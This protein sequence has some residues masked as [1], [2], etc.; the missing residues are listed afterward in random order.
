VETQSHLVLRN[1]DLSS[2]FA[3]FTSRAP[4]SNPPVPTPSP[5]LIRPSCAPTHGSQK[6]LAT[7]SWSSLR[8]TTS[9]SCF[10]FHVR[11]TQRCSKA[12]SV[13]IS[14]LSTDLQKSARAQQSLQYCSY[15]SHGYECAPACIFC[16]S[17]AERGPGY[18]SSTVLQESDCITITPSP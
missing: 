16:F 3:S 4:A 14:E 5:H 13:S 6:K 11:W 15:Q 9:N 8:C 2:Q 1:D 12:P 17:R 7:A 18:A 10:R